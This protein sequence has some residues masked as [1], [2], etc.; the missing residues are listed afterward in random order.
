M[1]A[2]Q[3]HGSVWLAG[4]TLTSVE[5]LSSKQVYDAWLALRQDTVRRSDG[6]SGLY[7]VV[8]SADCS[9]VIPPAGDRV[10]LRE[11]TG[12]IATTLRRLSAYALLLLT[13]PS[14]PE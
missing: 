8:E 9:L 13:A 11:E 7:S 6:A 1:T 3:A 2:G 10:H 12:L 14:S 4:C 5:T